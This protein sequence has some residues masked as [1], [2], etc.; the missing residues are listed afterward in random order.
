MQL[1]S[2]PF[3]VL[4]TETT[5]L[6]P[7]VNRVIEFA[8]VRYDGKDESKPYEQ[9]FS[10]PGTIPEQVVTLTRITDDDLEGCSSF[11]DKRAEVLEA[12]GE[13][14][15][16]IGQ[17]VS[18]DIRML[19][20]EGIDLSERPWIDTSMIASLVFPKLESYSLG[21]VS[22]V[23]DLNHEPVH[24][25]L[26]DVHATLELLSLC[27]ERLLELPDELRAPLDSIMAK[28]PEGYRLLFGALP[29]P[30]KTQ[31]PSWLSMPENIHLHGEGLDNLTLEKPENGVIQLVEE[32]FAPGF[33]SQVLIN[34]VKSGERCAIAV[35]N[36]H[37]TLRTMYVPEGVHV[38][39]P[40]YVMMDNTSIDAFA[41]QDVFT[42]D[43]ATLA[44]KIAWHEPS[45]RS[46]IPIHGN[47]RAVW[48]GKLVCTTNSTD[49]RKQ[50]DSEE[51]VFLLDH[52]QFLTILADTNHPGHAL[53]SSGI[54]AVIDDASML[55]DTA[56]KAYGQYCPLSDLRAAAEGNDSLTKFIDL[57]QIWVEK[58]RQTHDVHYI[59]SGNLGTPE[60]RGLREQLE[61]LLEGGT[62]PLESL[63]YSHLADL[64]TILQPELLAGR[65]CWIEQRQDGNQFVQSVPE[66]IA[67]LLSKYL[68]DK[69]AT[70]LLVPPGS[71]KS[72]AEILPADKKTQV[73]PSLGCEAQLQIAC[74]E[75]ETIASIL[76]NPPD[77][78]TVLLM[79]SRGKIEDVFVRYTA[80]ME[81]RGETL[82]CQNWG[83]G[84]GRMQAEFAAA[85][86]KVVWVITPWSFEIAELPLNS[87]DHLI[88][89]TLPF[90]HPSHTVLSKRAEHYR[91]AFN[92]YSLARLQHRL[93]RLLR[94]FCCYCPDNADAL[95]LDKRLKNKGY[96][97]N[98]WE[99]LQSLVCKN[100]E[101]KDGQLALF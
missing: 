52:Q 13:D 85:E 55:E 16:I 33:L 23:L 53:F 49:Y 8:S 71:A 19:K 40:P 54:H 14:T 99:Y 24:R 92:E 90:D 88:M 38:L 79:G 41:K 94:T 81:A 12:I 57:L 32:P 35:K 5:G 91:N 75:E 56:T 58:T 26:G 80:A 67:P 11:E 86:G 36:L 77:G 42:A 46:Q 4:D 87:I 47:E 22:K 31:K 64:R 18:F 100:D 65:I 93:H 44:V 1:P 9:L 84:M 51:K 61:E 72:L 82:I 59:S 73:V 95:F 69:C 83:G 39:H 60:T 6:I 48:N 45:M 21:Y 96:G 3:V 62:I 50:F 89:E 27:W 15:V 34:A 37:S 7:K 97:R 10:I 20:G 70:T 29:P 30:T 17:N 28:A 98:V 78:K 25:A 74:A 43:E 68:Y 2:F 66:Y 101:T 76:D 63:L